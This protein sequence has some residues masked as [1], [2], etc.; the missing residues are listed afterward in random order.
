MLLL[1][2]TEPSTKSFFFASFFPNVSTAPT[3]SESMD[4][5]DVKMETIPKSSSSIDEG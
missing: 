3:Q 5:V 1:I 2:T 4:V